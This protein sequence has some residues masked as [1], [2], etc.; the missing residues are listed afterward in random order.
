MHTAADVQ[1]RDPMTQLVQLLN[2]RC[3]GTFV[4]APFCLCVRLSCYPGH[5][6]NRPASDDQTAQ[7]KGKRNEKD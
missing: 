6:R 5:H 3:G 1:T 4:R 7:Q 2:R